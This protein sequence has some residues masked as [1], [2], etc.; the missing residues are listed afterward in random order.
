[1][2]SMIASFA[3]RRDSGK[4]AVLSFNTMAYVP[5][6]TIEQKVEDLWQLLFTNLYEFLL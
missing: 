3:K 5:S 4:N 1:M 2:Q 6:Y